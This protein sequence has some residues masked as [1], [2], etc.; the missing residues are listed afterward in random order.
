[1]QA[2][3]SLQSARMN[4]QSAQSNLRSF[5]GFNEKVELELVVDFNIPDL[6]VAYEKALELALSNSPDILSYERQLLE[7]QRSVAQARSQ[8]GLSVTLNGTYGK[9]RSAKE[10]GEVYSNLGDDYSLG[11]SIRIPVLDW[12]QGRNTYRNALSSRELVEVQMRQN[13]VDFEQQI[14]LQVMQF[15]MQGKQLEI[16][17]VA[18]TIA[19]KS[20]E[21][22]KQRYLIGRV[23]VTDLNIA[24]T[25]KDAAKRT[26]INELSTYWTQFYRLRQSTLFDF[27]NNRSLLE[28][29]FESLL[30]M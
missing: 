5:L 10:F 27:L 28:Q 7:S 3:S 9:S 18:D 2:Q 26:L 11:A 30:K 1:M 12:G 13:R 22:A 8:R 19:Q 15:N 17:S 20:Y 25:E 23:S 6:Q 16:A 24:D 14:F 4:L 29:D 21:V